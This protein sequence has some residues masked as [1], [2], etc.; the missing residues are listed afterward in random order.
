MIWT[1]LTAILAVDP[2]LAARRAHDDEAVERVLEAY[3]AIDQ[4]TDDPDLRLELRRICKRESWCNRWGMIAD[5]TNDG[6]AGERM[7]KRAVA[8]GWLTPETCGAHALGDPTHWTCRGLFGHSAA[9][10]IRHIDPDT[11]LGCIGPDTL[12][13]PYRAAE[14][15]VAYTEHLCERLDACT[16]EDRTR[17]WAGPG[18]WVTRSRL[19][20]L[21]AIETQCGP[22]P[23]RRWVGAGV[24][25]ALTYIGDLALWIIPRPYLSTR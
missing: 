3:D 8:K 22:V 10:A 9:Y 17:W 5:H 6:W 20:N 2:L 1:L 19:R 21:R 15:A 24:L 23:V 11:Y 13:D 16:C 18:V 14:A 7:W 12:D 4:A 25:D